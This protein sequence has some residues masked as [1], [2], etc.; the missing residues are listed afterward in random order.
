MSGGK[1][2]KLSFVGQKLTLSG[3]VRSARIQYTIGDDCA[4]SASAAVFSTATV[5]AA[6]AAPKRVK[7]KSKSEQWVKGQVRPA[8]TYGCTVNVWEEDF[9][10]IRMI[11]MQNHTTWE[12]DSR[13]ISSGRV[14][15]YAHSNL[16]WWWVNGDP[17][18]DIGYVNAPH[19]GGSFAG[20]NF[21]C[22]GS[23]FCRT[24]STKGCGIALVGHFQF[25]SGGECSGWGSFEGEIVPQGRFDYEV[26][27]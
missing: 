21:F 19:V 18:V 7:S 14:N 20:A 8:A 13:G 15:G 24:C 11:N 3:N 5:V 26:T 25:N 16:D 22:D 9:P 12:A 17:V 2:C 27:R 10:G 6:S 1:K 23:N 4:V